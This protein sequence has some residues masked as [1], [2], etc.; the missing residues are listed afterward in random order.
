[1]T[2]KYSQ[3]TTEAKKNGLTLEAFIEL[4]LQ[5][6]KGTLRELGFKNHQIEQL[7]STRQKRTDTL[8]PF[9]RTDILSRYKAFCEMLKPFE[10]KEEKIREILC[11]GLIFSQMPAALEDLLVYVQKNHFSP[12]TFLEK[13]AD[14]EIGREVLGQSPGKT[15][16]NVEMMGTALKEYGVSQKEW[17]E[18]ALKRRNLFKITP[19]YL[20]KN[21][22]EMSLF[23]NNFGYGCADWIKAAQRNPSILDKPALTLQK[24]TEKM[25]SFLDAFGIQPTLWIE[26]GL[27]L[28]QILYQIPENMQKQ[29]QFIMDMYQKDDFIFTQLPKKDSAHLMHYL[30]N[31][32]QY[33][34]GSEETLVLRKK[35]AAFLNKTRG[36]ATSEIIYRTKKYILAAMGDDV[37]TPISSQKRFN[38]KAPQ[39]KTHSMV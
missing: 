14:D 6:I 12:A 27:R 19:E 13:M 10:L 9:E 23:L 30:L 36:Y 29:I 22:K 38:H 31:S 26:S 35:Y 3:L 2:K 28:P 37:Q 4:K 20:L 21:I 5:P 39:Q 24:K 25:F 17:I 7:I 18:L 15:K 16:H 32:P 34:C 11:Q 8:I 1:M 33:F